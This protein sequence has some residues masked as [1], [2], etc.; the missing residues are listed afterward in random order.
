MQ[1]F[2]LI[3]YRN[4]PYRKTWTPTTYQQTYDIQTGYNIASDGATTTSSSRAHQVNNTVDNSYFGNLPGLGSYVDHKVK[5][6]ARLQEIVNGLFGK[7]Q[8]LPKISESLELCAHI[9]AQVAAHR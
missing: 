1:Y 7:K 8:V 6:L 3:V 9:V 5:V 2:F 4:V